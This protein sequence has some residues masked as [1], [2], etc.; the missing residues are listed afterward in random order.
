M[1]ATVPEVLIDTG[2]AN[3]FP[4]VLIRLGGAGGREADLVKVI[5]KIKVSLSVCVCVCVC[6]HLC[7]CACVCV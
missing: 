2:M 5:C 6:V 7:V 4:E 1:Q 3:L